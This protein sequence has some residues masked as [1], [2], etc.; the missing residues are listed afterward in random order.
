MTTTI[1]AKLQK[2]SQYLPEWTESTTDSGSNHS[3]SIFFFCLLEWRNSIAN[4]SDCL[5]SHENRTAPMVAAVT[6]IVD[7]VVMITVEVAVEAS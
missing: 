6:A 7:N 3:K 1:L 4:L 5:L 2:F